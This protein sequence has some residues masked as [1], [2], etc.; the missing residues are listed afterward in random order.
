MTCRLKC[1]EI[2]EYDDI[3]WLQPPED[4]ASVIPV[5]RVHIVGVLSGWA[6]LTGRTVDDHAPLLQVIQRPSIAPAAEIIDLTLSQPDAVVVQMPSATTTSNA[7]VVLTSCPMCGFPVSS[8][9]AL[10]AHLAECLKDMI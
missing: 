1:N 4:D 8:L 7:G 6:S 5:Q 9:V 3:Q 2:H 10:D